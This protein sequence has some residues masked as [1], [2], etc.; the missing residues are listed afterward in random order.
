MKSMA[1]ER[2][3]TMKCQ[4]SKDDPTK[5]APLR[6]CGVLIWQKRPTFFEAIIF[7]YSETVLMGPPCARNWSLL[8]G[9]V[10]RG[11]Q[12]HDSWREVTRSLE[13]QLSHLGYTCG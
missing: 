12:P 13:D 3:E 9:F 8:D 10:A 5:A 7:Q 11:F 6:R 1:K 2:K 4:T